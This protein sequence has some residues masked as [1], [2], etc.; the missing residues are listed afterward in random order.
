MKDG[1]TYTDT[2]ADEELGT[3]DDETDDGQRQVVGENTTWSLS[4]GAEHSCDDDSGSPAYLQY[5]A[6][7]K[8]KSNNQQGL[9][10]SDL[11]PLVC[12]RCLILNRKYC[13]DSDT[14][15]V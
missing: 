1:S 14:C 2:D 5:V 4:R 3:T 10:G 6:C 9:Q 7:K 8:Q 13:Q 12:G 11:S 15:N